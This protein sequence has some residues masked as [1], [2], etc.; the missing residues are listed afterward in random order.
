MR[1]RMRSGFVDVFSIN[2]TAKFWLQCAPMTKICM[3]FQ[4]VWLELT[5]ALSR[6]MWIV[7]VINHIFLK[8]P[9]EEVK[10]EWEEISNVVKLTKAENLLCKKIITELHVLVH[11]DSSSLIKNSLTAAFHYTQTQLPLSAHRCV[12]LITRWPP[13]HAPFGTNVEF[14][15]T[16][17]VGPSS[18]TILARISTLCTQK[19]GKIKTLRYTQICRASERW[20][21]S[22]DITIQTPLNVHP[23]PSLSSSSCHR[24]HQ[25]QQEAYHTRINTKNSPDN[26]HSQNI[27]SWPFQY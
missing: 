7:F 6:P 19:D 5:V 21:T 11:A 25:K 15:L 4:Y 1:I 14:L 23:Y 20:R 9:L 24:I 13:R 17:C 22:V 10:R 2:G 18:Y 26:G 3:S 8:T 16:I 27:A 12:K